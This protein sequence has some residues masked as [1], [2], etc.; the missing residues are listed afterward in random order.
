MPLPS[1]TMPS[2]ATTISDASRRASSGWRPSAS[3]AVVNRS[4]QADSPRPV[5]SASAG[6]S[7]AVSRATAATAHPSMKS[8][9]FSQAISSSNIATT[10]ASTEPHSSSVWAMRARTRSENRSSAAAAS[11]SFPPGKWKYIDPLGASASAITWLR[12]V[13]A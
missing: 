3:S 1:T 9:R 2:S 10:A 4:S 5:A 7:P 11:S 13:A 8:V 12:P 6:C